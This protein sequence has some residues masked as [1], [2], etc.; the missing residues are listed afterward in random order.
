MHCCRMRRNQPMSSGETGSSRKYRRKS[1]HVLAEADRLGRGQALVDVVEELDLVTELLPGRL[2][3]PERAPR[4]GRR[5]EDGGCVEGGDRGLASAR[6]V[7]GHPG[8]AHL[9]AHVSEAA[10]HVR[11]GVVE[12][13]GD[14]RPARVGVAVHRLA[15]LAAE[16]LVDGHPGLSPLDV[17]QR[18]VDAADRVVEDGAVSPVR[19]RVEGLP[20]VLDPVRG[21]ADEERLEVAVHRG[22]DEIGPL[23]EG[24]AAVAVQAVLVR[25][26]LHHDEPQPCRR[27]GDRA[28][29]GDLR[30]RKASQRLLRPRVRRGRS[31]PQKPRGRAARRQP[32][33]LTPSHASLPRPVPVVGRD[34]TPGPPP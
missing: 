12:H 3:E 31:R 32:E 21:L 8:N 27:G 28:H 4:V 11:P 15:G 16:E 29:V 6:A 26:D 30:R 23:R 22:R 14:L 20:G 17:P 7:A 1:L 25:R 18:H 33:R 9:H 19:A 34:A 5:L 2:E 10:G 24:G 13:L